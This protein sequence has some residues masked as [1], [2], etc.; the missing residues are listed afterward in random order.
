MAEPIPD[1]AEI[2]RHVDQD[3]TEM[4]AMQAG[5]SLN[6]FPLLMSVL[7]LILGA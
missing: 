1:R 5:T 3:G 4:C 6:C 2:H 7:R